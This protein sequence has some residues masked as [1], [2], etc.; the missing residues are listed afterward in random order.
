MRLSA[1]L[2]GVALTT[3]SFRPLVNVWRA[4]VCSAPRSAYQSKPDWLVAWNFISRSYCR[5]YCQRHIIRPRLTIGASPGEARL[6][7]EWRRQFKPRKRMVPSLKLAIEYRAH[8][9]PIKTHTA[10]LSLRRPPSLNT[11]IEKSYDTLNDA[12]RLRRTDHF[13]KC[14]AHFTRSGTCQASV[15]K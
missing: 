13:A 8:G 12:K 9:Y 6:K 11:P 2:R 14:C 5:S 1:I 7:P 15:L 10:S 4:S 3:T